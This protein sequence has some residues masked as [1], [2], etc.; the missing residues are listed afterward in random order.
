MPGEILPPWLQTNPNEITQQYAYGVQ[1]GA[2]IAQQHQSLQARQQQAAMEAQIRQQQLDQQAEMQRQ[3][4]KLDQSY[5]DQLI[6]WHQAQ[7]Q[8]AAQKNAIGIQAAARKFAA[9]EQY[10]TRVAAGEDPSK[11]ML[12]LGPEMGAT[13]GLASLA[14]KQPTPGPVEGYPVTMGGKQLPGMVAVPGA[15][16]A[17]ETRNIPGYKPEG[18]SASERAQATSILRQEAKMLLTEITDL[19]GTRTQPPRRADSKEQWDADTTR[20]QEIEDQLRQINPILGNLKAPTLAPAPG[21]AT[22]TGAAPAGQGIKIIAIRPKKAQPVYQPTT[23]EES[24]GSAMG[25]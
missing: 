6:G 23:P 22:G 18:I 3:K 9:T 7:L 24:M 4:I 20:L 12:E 15:S 19:G 1:L 10:R 11:V 8:E 2:Q 13:A 16:G 14:R 5:H 17:M 25:F 21:T